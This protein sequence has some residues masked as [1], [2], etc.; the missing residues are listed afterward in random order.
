MTWL[1]TLIGRDRF[2]KPFPSRTAGALASL[3][4]A[5]SF[6]LE[7]FMAA[8]RGEAG[9][10]YAVTATDGQYRLCASLTE[11]GRSDPAAPIFDPAAIPDKPAITERNGDRWL[12]VPCGSLLVLQARLRRGGALPPDLLSRADRLILTA[13]TLME[14]ARK[15]QESQMEA[16]LLKA[17]LTAARMASDVALKPH[18]ALEILFHIPLRLLNTT[19][20]GLVLTESDGGGPSLA[21]S[22]GQGALWT[23]KL[24]AGAAP[25]LLTATDVPDLV[26]GPALGALRSEGILAVARVPARGEG[27]C[28]YYF[29][30]ED[31]PRP[32]MTA[33]SVLSA[34]F[35]RLLAAN[36]QTQQT[37]GLY[38]DTL[39]SLVDSLD[40]A[41]PYTAGHSDRMARYAQMTAREL[42]LP[43][44]QVAA[45]GLA[46]YLHDVGMVT[47][48][49][50]AF[51]RDG[52]LTT[53]EYALVQEH[54]RIGAEL[55]SPLH[56][57]LPLSPMVAHHHERW[58]GRGYP[59]RLKAKD[60]PI[61]ARIIAVADLFEAKTTGRA[62][63]RPLPFERALADLQALG[64]TQLDPDVVA[65][66]VRA[67][68][69]LRRQAVP[70]RPL[71]RCWE[72]RQ[73]PAAVCGECPNRAQEAPEPCWENPG[74]R[75]ERHGEECASCVVYTEAISRQ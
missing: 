14:T 52:R 71:G 33:L 23:V 39:R 73:V 13:S 32:P 54:T 36:S 8:V 22:A 17:G 10:A 20:G 12:T 4:E 16:A 68:Q 42:G 11:P 26:T 28:A 66:F 18:R 74:R 48:D 29:L 47:I 31:L 1:D 6:C 19:D 24:L 75:C 57:A 58:D 59:A 70:G 63:R 3:E 21:A 69:A 2:L 65:A 9:H 67:F 53:K 55:V 44:G 45:V 50:A 25:L 60:I 41:L 5:A 61:G 30:N 7:H 43:D 49:T 62:Y 40:Q 15:L 37:A 72:L 34:Q 64:G 27:G 56:A 38:L 51:L 46:A 35:G